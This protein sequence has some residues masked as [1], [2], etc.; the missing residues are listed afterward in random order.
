MSI[1]VFSHR[2]ISRLYIKSIEG[3]NLM[4]RIL[5]EIMKQ[6][7]VVCTVFAASKIS[8]F[9]ERHLKLSKLRWQ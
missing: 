6:S 2:V 4:S 7:V 9:V 1:A 5:I 8:D 3:L